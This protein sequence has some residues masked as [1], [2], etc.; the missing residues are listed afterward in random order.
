M[1]VSATDRHTRP[2]RE[3]ER[4]ITRPGPR[5]ERIVTRSR[6]ETIGSSPARPGDERN[7]SSHRRRGGAAA[8]SPGG[9][10]CALGGTPDPWTT[11]PSGPVRGQGA[12][13]ALPKGRE[14]PLTPDAFSGRMVFPPGEGIGRTRLGRGVPGRAEADPGRRTI[15]VSGALLAGIPSH[16]SGPERGI[17]GHLGEYANRSPDG[18]PDPY[19]YPYPD[20]YP[21]PYPDGY[22]GHPGTWGTLRRAGCRRS[23][24]SAGPRHARFLRVTGPRYAWRRVR[25]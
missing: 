11:G 2:W 25:D 12:P 1:R 17:L 8:P 23:A 15:A 3:D 7:G 4:I 14:A 10:R 20:G 16:Q 24:R 22:P 19:P 18:Y 5:A 21:D 13:K 6:S 9:G